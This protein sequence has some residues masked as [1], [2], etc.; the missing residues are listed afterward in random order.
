MKIQKYILML[1]EDL[2]LEVQKE[3]QELLEEK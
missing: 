3:I 2:L 1:L